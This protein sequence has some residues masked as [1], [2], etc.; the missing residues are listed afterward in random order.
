[1]SKLIYLEQSAL[2]TWLVSSR[3]LICQWIS[4]WLLPSGPR[5][6]PRLSDKADSGTL[7]KAGFLAKFTWLK[8]H[9]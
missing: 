2:P 4:D 6:G 5:P 7:E 9:F 3:F 1:M 8:I